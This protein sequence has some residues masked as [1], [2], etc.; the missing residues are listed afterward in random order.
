MCYR[1]M[2]LEYR[3]AS[4]LSLWVASCLCWEVGLREMARMCRM[5]GTW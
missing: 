1:G 5:K 2:K 3:D 4:S